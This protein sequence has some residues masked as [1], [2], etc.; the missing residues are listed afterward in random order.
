MEDRKPKYKLKDIY[1][2]AHKKNL[3]YWE[4]LQKVLDATGTRSQHLA[5]TRT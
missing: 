3:G 2:Q 1:P 4:R 5:M